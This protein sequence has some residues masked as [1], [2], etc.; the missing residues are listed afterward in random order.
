MSEG[1][2]LKV[3]TPQEVQERLTKELPEWSY[4]DGYLIRNVSNKDWKETVLLFG[5]IAYISEAHWHHPDMEVSFKNLKV[6]LTTHE[7]GGITERD[8]DLAKEIEKTLSMRRK[9]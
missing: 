1:R 2:D 4:Q 8:F 3:Y 5:A 7:F 9:K 6:K